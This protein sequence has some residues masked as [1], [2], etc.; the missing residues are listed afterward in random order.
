MKKAAWKI[1]FVM[2][3]T[4]CTREVAI[5][6]LEAEEWDCDDAVTSYLADQRHNKGE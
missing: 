1:P 4:A 3:Y 6:Y 2:R 5:A